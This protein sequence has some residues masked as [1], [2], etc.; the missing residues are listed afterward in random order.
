MADSTGLD[1]KDKKDT[2]EMNEETIMLALKELS[3]DMKWV[4]RILGVMSGL[5]IT[6]I[7]IMLK[8]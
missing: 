3:T 8:G 2:F 1:Y 7:T 6:L 5:F 4:K